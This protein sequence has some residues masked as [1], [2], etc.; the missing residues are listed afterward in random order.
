MWGAGWGGGGEA[1]HGEAQREI[2]CPQGGGRGIGTGGTHR[3]SGSGSRRSWPA[4]AAPRPRT[5]WYERQQRCQLAPAPFGPIIADPPRDA[6]VEPQGQQLLQMGRGRVGWGGA[7]R[8]WGACPGQAGP[9][10]V[11]RAGTEAAAEGEGGL[12]RAARCGRRVR[13]SRSRREGEV[14]QC[15]TPGTLRR[16]C[17]QQLAGSGAL[18]G[19]PGCGEG[20]WAGLRC[21]HRHVPPPSRM[22]AHPHPAHHHPKQHA[23]TARQGVADA[24]AA[25]APILCS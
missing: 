20:S 8:G 17:L 25:P 21:R 14:K 16:C 15:A 11:G 2:P 23:Q 13:T 4:A 10:L 7:G 5:I 3:S 18:V 6:D 9:G 19:V 22:P 12:W 1:H 24:A